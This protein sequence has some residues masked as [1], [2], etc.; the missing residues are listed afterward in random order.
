MDLIVRHARLRDEVPLADLGIADGRIACIAPTLPG[1]APEEID[2]GGRV[3]IPGLVETHLHLDKALLAERRANYSGTLSEAI[4]ITGELKRHFTRADVRTRAEAALRMALRHGTTAIRAETEFDPIVGLMG[5]EELLGLKQ[6][7]A[8][9][10]DIQ[11]VAFPQEGVH[12]TP[13]TEELFWRAMELGADVVGG[14]PYNDISA[15]R[16][17][18]LCFQIAFHYNKPISL[19]QDFRD[20]PD[21]LSIEYVAHETIARGWQGRVEVGHATALGAIEPAR[22]A[23]ILELLREADITVVSL[24]ATDLHLGA[25]SDTHNVRRALAPVRA[26]IDAGVNVAVSSNNIRNAFTPYGTG[27]LLLSAFLLVATAHLGGA[28]MLPG[29]IDL[30]TTNAARAIGIGDQYGLAV[31]RKADLVVLDTQRWHDV[32]T[33]MPEKLWVL[34]DGHVTVVNRQSTEFRAGPLPA[35]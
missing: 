11:V 6:R 22:L 21:G 16:H 23:P 14:V 18:D 4:R 32:V 19:H 24:P 10:V 35:A 25:R 2:A 7:Y 34:K 12:R 33:D 31:G 28:E 30:V 17:I 26:L 3:V 5:I 20:D 13:G 29:V 27:D 1:S 9:L 8:P 15:E